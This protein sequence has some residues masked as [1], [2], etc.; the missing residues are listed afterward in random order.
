MISVMDP[1]RDAGRDARWWLTVVVVPAVLLV[2]TLA[3]PAVFAGRLPSRLAT[4]WGSEGS[5]S[6]GSVFLLQ[7]VIVGGI[8]GV[9]VGY[10]RRFMP[11]SPSVFTAYFL[12]GL[13]LAAEVSIVVGNLDAAGWQ[14]ADRLS[15]SVTR[16]RRP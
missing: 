13:F 1:F 10:G 3:L 14:Q 2:V 6:L 16:Y 15:G 12:L 11:P 9:L 8:W 4:H 5:M 7:L